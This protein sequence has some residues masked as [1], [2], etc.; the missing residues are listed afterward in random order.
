MSSPRLL[1]AIH[2]DGDARYRVDTAGTRA[3]LIP[4]ACR[5][6]LHRLGRAGYRVTEAEGVLRVRCD[7]C[8]AAGTPDSVWIFR[9][10][11]PIA[12]IAEIDDWPAGLA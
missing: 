12:T 2:F 3:V 1:G 8:A 4:G 11:G 9:G 5:L 10:T 7:A 6:G